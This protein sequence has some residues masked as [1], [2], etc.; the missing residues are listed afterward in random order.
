MVPL[1]MSLQA[2]V[3]G[4]LV[5]VLDG[6]LAEVLDGAPEAGTTS[7]GMCKG[8]SWPAGALPLTVSR[9]A[10][11]GCDD[12]TAQMTTTQRAARV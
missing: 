8:P 7:S 4:V 2:S 3:N 9:P 6:V 11:T 1:Q 12:A 10:R 5:G